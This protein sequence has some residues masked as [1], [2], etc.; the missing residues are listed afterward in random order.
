MRHAHPSRTILWVA[1]VFAATGLI[2][3]WLR[4]PEQLPRAY[5]EA[6]EGL[7]AGTRTVLGPGDFLWLDYGALAGA[8]KDPLS[9]A[10]VWRLFMGLRLARTHNRS[11]AEIHGAELL[12]KPDNFGAGAYVLIAAPIMVLALSFLGTRRSRGNSW[13]FVGAVVM[14]GIYGLGRWRVAATEGARAAAGIEIGPG[15]WLTMLAALLTGVIF[16]L[17]WFFP[18]AKWL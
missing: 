13:L 17:R 8:F 16:I 14:L 6:A 7:D 1:V 5:V 15:A 18:K 9:G 11:P 10:N 2:A 12:V 3:P 4:G